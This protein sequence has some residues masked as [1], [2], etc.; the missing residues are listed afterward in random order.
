MDVKRFIDTAVDGRDLVRRVG[1]FQ[2]E[3]VGAVSGQVDIGQFSDVHRYRIN[4]NLESVIGRSSGSCSFVIPCL[5]E[6]KL[7]LS[8]S[9]IMKKPDGQEQQ[10]DRID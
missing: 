5:E 2:I 4:V 9:R 7:L 6:G 1:K 8:L 10:A 3:P